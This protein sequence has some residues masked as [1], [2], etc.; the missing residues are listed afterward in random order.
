MPRVRMAMRERLTCQFSLATTPA[1]TPLGTRWQ[2][3]EV[4]AAALVLVAPLALR[5]LVAA[6]VKVGAATVA[7]EPAAALV[8][9]VPLAL[10]G[11]VAAPVEAGAAA[12]EARAER[13]AARALLAL[14]VL[15]GPVAAPVKVEE[16]AREARAVLAAARVP[17]APAV[18]AVLA[19]R[20][21]FGVRSATPAPG[22]PRSR[23]RR[24]SIP[25]ARP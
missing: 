5:G 15:R 23:P 12:K 4:P 3:G 24:R 22:I 13:A 16:E 21:A 7:R 11:P 20:A 18:P 6:P 9:V 17:A 2:V 19:E 8:L 1:L 25:T 14:V 10:R